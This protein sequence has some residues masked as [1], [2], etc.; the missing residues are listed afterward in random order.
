MSIVVNELY[1]AGIRT[2]HPRRHERG[3]STRQSRVGSVVITVGA[4]T[5]QGA[6]DDVAPPEFPAAADPFLTVELADAAAELGVDHH[7]GVT[8][9]T[10]TFFEGQERSGVVGQPATCCAGCAG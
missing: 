9:S 4:V 6:A 7:V 8:A 5:N 3:R 10:D 2:D 1:Q